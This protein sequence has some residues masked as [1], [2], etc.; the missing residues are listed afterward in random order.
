MLGT[1]MLYWWIVLCIPVGMYIFVKNA[2]PDAVGKT[3][4]NIIKSCAKAN[5]W[6]WLMVPFFIAQASIPYLY[7]YTKSIIIKKS[8][9]IYIYIYSIH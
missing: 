5:D 9:Y 2:P 3:P 8:N 6:M 7:K 4:P 1:Y